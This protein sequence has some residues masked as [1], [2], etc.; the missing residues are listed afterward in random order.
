MFADKEVGGLV[1]YDV[2]LY[3]A[4]NKLGHCLSVEQK[5]EATAMPVTQQISYM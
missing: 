5:I 4:S 1:Y 2:S 3:L